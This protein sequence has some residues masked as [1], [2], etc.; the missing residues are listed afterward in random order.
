MSHWKSHFEQMLQD[1]LIP[2]PTST[3]EPGERSD[4]SSAT[5]SRRHR[6][7]FEKKFKILR[8]T[9]NRQ[10]KVHEVLKKECDP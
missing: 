10:G 8:C 5:K 6:L 9:L 3:C 1:L 7:S 2:I 4:L